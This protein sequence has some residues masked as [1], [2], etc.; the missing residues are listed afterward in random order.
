MCW[1]SSKSDTNPARVPTIRRQAS[2]G[3]TTQKT[4]AHA[5]QVPSSTEN[6]LPQTSEEAEQDSDK[7]QDSAGL[8][9]PE[10]AQSARRGQ[11][12]GRTPDTSQVWRRR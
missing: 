11:T 1:E 7:G 10:M 2:K 12:S 6:L 3:A 4:V 5:E 9:A 8:T